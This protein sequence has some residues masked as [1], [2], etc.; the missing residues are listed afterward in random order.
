MLDLLC[1]TCEKIDTEPNEEILESVLLAADVQ[2]QRPPKDIDELH[3][4]VLVQLHLPRVEGMELGV[5]S[6]E[7]PLHG[8]KVQGFKVVGDLAGTGLFGKALSLAGAHYDHRVPVGVVG[9]E[10]LQAHTEDQRNPQQGGEG[11]KEPASLNLGEQ[12]GG[13]AGVAAELN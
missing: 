3:A 6:V 7:L 12:A 8:R 5:I 4:G 13:E 2:A 1:Q 10:V 11:G 9:K